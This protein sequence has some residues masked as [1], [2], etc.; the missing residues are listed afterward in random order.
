LRII[1]V[2]R[3]SHIAEDKKSFAYRLTFLN[4][5]DTLTDTIVNEAITSIDSSLEKQLK[6]EIR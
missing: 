5:N 2:Y 3:G 6:A 1:D 4:E